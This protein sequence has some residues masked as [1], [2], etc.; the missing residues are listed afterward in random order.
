MSI[1]V[2]VI[3]V[4]YRTAEMLIDCVSKMLATIDFNS[5]SI[6]IIDNHSNDCSVTK[7]KGWLQ[8]CGL[9]SRITL[10]SSPE[11]GGFSAGNNIGISA[12]SA[13]YYLLLNSDAYIEQSSIELLLK[14]F[15]RDPQI[16]LVS[17][18][19]QW[20]DGKP[21]ESTFNFFHPITEFVQQSKTGIFSSLFKKFVVAEPVCDDARYVHWAS[22]ACIMISA[23]CLE[24]VGLLD[25]GY[26]MYFEDV[27]Y[28]Y[29]AQKH[30]YKV[31]HEPSACAVHLRGGSSSV[32]ANIAKRKRLPKYFYQ[33]RTRFY[34]QKYGLIGLFSA[35]VCWYL[36]RGVSLMRQLLGGNDFAAIENQW[37]DIW[38]N[39]SQPL[40]AYSHPEKRK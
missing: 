19:L 5:V 28:C 18:R 17:P 12:I 15:G 32:K 40:G 31:F 27:E 23:E 30:N 14:A 4:N 24:E 7:L 21:Q 29:R 34:Y 38:L 11:N 13:D 1:N 33:S 2:A 10:I 16:G 9:T 25:E 35:N 39:F 3:I 22:F 8:N 20:E 6:F 36:G 26:F 37:K